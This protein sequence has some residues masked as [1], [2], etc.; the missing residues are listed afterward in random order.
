MKKE[1]Q[2]ENILEEYKKMRDSWLEFM[3]YFKEQGD[4]EKANMCLENASKIWALRTD[5]EPI[6]LDILTP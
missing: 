1:K 2:K 6:I 4:V 5:I 3:V